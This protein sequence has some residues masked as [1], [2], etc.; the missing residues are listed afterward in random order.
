MRTL[1]WH[2]AA[3]GPGA[4]QR[5]VYRLD[6]EYVPVRAWMHAATAPTA[7]ELIIDIN[8]DGVSI[9]TYQPRL[10]DEQDAESS[11]FASVQCSK[12]ALVSLDIDQADGI[13]VNLTVGLELEDA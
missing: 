1:T 5:E 8:V 13:A 3:I 10:R 6:G 11:D 2:I 4:S 12:D 7:R 9:F